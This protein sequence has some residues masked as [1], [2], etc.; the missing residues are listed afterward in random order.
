MWL[1]DLNELV[2]TLKERIKQHKDVLGKNETATR[3]ALIDPLLTALG[4][5]L[6]DPGQVRTE[7]NPDGTRGRRSDY[8]MFTSE[9]KKK[10]QLVIEAKKLGN[11]IN[12]EVIEQTIA[13]CVKEGIPHFVVTNGSDWAIYKTSGDVHITEKRIVEF[14]LEAPTQNAVMKM[15]TLW[16]GN[17]ESESPIVPIAPDRPVLQQAATS[18][19]QPA[20]AAP[21][22]SVQQPDRGIPLDEFSPGKGAR[23]PAT[24][25]FPGGMEK[26][27]AWWYEIQ[28]SVVRWLIDT[29]R[30]AEADCPV[31]GP[32]GRYLVATSPNKRNGGKFGSSKQIDSFFIDAVGSVSFHIKAAK[33]ILKARNVDLSDVRVVMET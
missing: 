5:D 4:W 18:A 30:L 6:Q 1:D 11:P 13:Y 17:F 24:L 33:E 10:P 16:R 2:G 32:G 8:T 26:N 3:Y 29:G 23:P 12:D 21:P 15:L 31:K 28:T 14:K 7:Y 22:P 19:P 9:D 20:A 25:L 27:I